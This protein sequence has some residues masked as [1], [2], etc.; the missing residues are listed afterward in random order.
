MDLQKRKEQEEHFI[1]YEDMHTSI[2]LKQKH[3]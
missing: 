2:T 3:C 1:I